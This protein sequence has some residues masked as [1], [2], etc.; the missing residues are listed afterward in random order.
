MLEKKERVKN[1]LKKSDGQDATNSVWQILNDAFEK[2]RDGMTIQELNVYLILNFIMEV[3]SGGFESFFEHSYG[4]YTEETLKALKEVK[5]V[6][7]KNLF[8]KAVLEFPGSYVPKDM[9]ERRKIKESIISKAEVVWD[10]LDNE[11]YKY[12]ENIDEL[13]IEYINDNIRYFS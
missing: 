4:D 7:F 3:H 13:L 11:C 1:V 5:S 2:D 9:F 6:I 8:E 10:S 12:E